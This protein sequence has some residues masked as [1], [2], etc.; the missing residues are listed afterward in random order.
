M[1]DRSGIHA[2]LEQLH[3]KYKGTGYPDISRCEWAD[4][5]LKDT[6]ASNISHYSRLAYFAVVENTTTSRIR[7][8]SLESMTTTCVPSTEDLV[9]K[10]N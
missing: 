4:N 1:E 2:Q 3:S 5:I 9:D 6:A 8:R 7:Y 10:D